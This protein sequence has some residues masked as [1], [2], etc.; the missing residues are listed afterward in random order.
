MR[1]LYSTTVS[2]VDVNT[3][4][5][6]TAGCQY[7]LI[8]L[9]QALDAGLSEK[10]I[11]HRVATRD[12][13]AVRRGVFRVT[14]APRSWRQEVLAKVLAA[15]DGAVAAGMTAPALW[16]IPGFPSG[17]IEVRNQYGKSRRHLQSGPAQSCLLLPHHCTVVDRI[18]VTTPTRALFDAIPLIHP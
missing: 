17:V 13:T 7:A 4:I 16:R 9:R 1:P 5:A 8:T 3:K 18:P 14:A 11:R 12:W 2:K 6:A 15:G 10:A